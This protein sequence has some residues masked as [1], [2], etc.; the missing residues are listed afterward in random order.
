MHR[1]NTF[2]SNPNRYRSSIMRAIN[3][4]SNGW[5]DVGLYQNSEPKRI[6]WITEKEAESIM[7][8]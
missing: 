5:I 2:P 6:R 1:E 3:L 4:Q 8:A 7:I